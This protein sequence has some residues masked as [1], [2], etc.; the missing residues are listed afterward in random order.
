MDFFF[1]SYFYLNPL[2]GDSID[3]TNR[4]R[5]ISQIL[6]LNSQFIVIYRIFLVS[7]YIFS[8][9]NYDNFVLAEP[10]YIK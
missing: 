10:H 3:F 4:K 5:N 2:K 8:I 1:V 9:Y 7:L 6:L